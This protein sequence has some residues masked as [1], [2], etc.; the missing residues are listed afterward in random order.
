[1]GYLDTTVIDAERA[2]NVKV[3]AT[4]NVYIERDKITK[5]ITKSVYVK[6]GTNE[7]TLCNQFSREIGNITFS[8]SPGVN[9]YSKTK[10]VTINYS[11]KNLSN[12]NSKIEYKYDY[13]DSNGEVDNNKHK[14]IDYKDITNGHEKNVEVYDQGMIIAKILVNDIE[15]KSATLEIGGFDKTGPTSSITSTKISWSNEQTATLTCTD[16]ES[17]VSEYYFGKTNPST[18][19]VSYTKVTN[20]NNFSTNEKVTSE[21]TYYLS[22]KDEYGNISNSNVE[23]YKYTV[24]N[25]LEKANGIEGTYTAANYENKFTDSY[26][27]TKGETVV[28]DDIKKIPDY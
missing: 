15:V 3:L 6:D 19:S 25:M 7:A 27:I 1:M 26:I 9:D 28:F 13:L 5:A 21:G 4:D 17:G 14:L 2:E 8:S 11:I 12:A 18:S 10:T 22:C 20:T 23:Y 16:N 24:Y